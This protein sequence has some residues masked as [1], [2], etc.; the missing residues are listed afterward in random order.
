MMRS[1][2][3]ITVFVLCLFSLRAYAEPLTID[4][5]D[6]HVKITTGFTGASLVLF[7]SITQKG[8]VI[9]VLEGPERKSKVRRKEQIMGAWINRN[10]LSFKNIP[11]YYD[12]AIS[13]DDE[14][15]VLP[16]DKLKEKRVGVTALRF[17]PEKSRYK[18]EVVSTF[19][20]A[21]I[22]NKQRQALFPL[23]PQKV[24]FISDNLFRADFHLPAN[25]PSGEYKV[26]AL[27]V[28]NNKVVYEQSRVLRV[29]YEGFNARIYK[30]ASDHSF[31]YG[32]L[33]VFIALIAG[34]A[35]NAIVR[36]N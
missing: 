5:A 31:L 10:W 15:D 30:F 27:L 6:N 16:A 34:W 36:R 13:A 8:D 25:V 22:R 14:S 17:D 20:D 32:V 21:L 11:S 18:A 28:R 29:G 3:F 26:R 2:G 24:G 9:V 23:E 19:Q 12:Y 33:C 1:A 7:G 35:S 4:L